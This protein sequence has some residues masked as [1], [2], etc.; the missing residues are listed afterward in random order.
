MAS[1]REEVRIEA[2]YVQALAA[3]E[4]RLGLGEDREEGRCVLVLVAPLAADR[5]LARTVEAR[6]RKLEE[7]NY[8]ARFVLTWE[9]G[10]AG[11]AGIPT[12][13][14]DGTVTLRAGEDYNQSDLVLE[15]T[16]T[17]P[18]GAIGELFDAL[19]HRRIAHATLG[20]LLEGMA[21]ELETEHRAIESAKHR[22]EDLAF[23]VKGVREQ[24]PDGDK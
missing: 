4:R 19:A 13:S 2:P 12:P 17:P 24:D 1:V 14:F 5:A 23:D 21:R 3:L 15:G 22:P 10:T 6:T 8:S 7:A 16:Y 11:P 9:A 18:G 20:A